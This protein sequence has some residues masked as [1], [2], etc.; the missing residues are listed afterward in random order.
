MITYLKILKS[1]FDIYDV[2]VNQFIFNAKVVSIFACIS[3]MF[4]FRLFI[5]EKLIKKNQ[6]LLAHLRNRMICYYI[7]Q[8]THAKFIL[9][10]CSISEKLL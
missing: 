10:M 9:S 6:C 7:T 8:F 3:Y 4:F 5:L 1:W 2:L